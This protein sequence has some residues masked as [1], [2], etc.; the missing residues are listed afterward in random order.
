MERLALVG[1]AL[2]AAL[3]AALALSPYAFEWRCL[4]CKNGATVETDPA[5]LA[6][7]SPGLARAEVPPGFARTL[8][9]AGTMTIEMTLAPRRVAQSG[10]ARIL[11]HS[12]SPYSRNFTLGQD[13]DALVLRFRTGDVD[14]NGRINEI[15]L[16]EVFTDTAEIRLEVTHDRTGTTVVVDGAE[17]FE[18]PNARADFTSWNDGFDL[19]VGNE[20]T[21]D[22]P[23]LGVV[24][25]LVIA[26][27]PEAPALVD[28]DFA[29]STEA[30]SAPA[31]LS[32]LQIPRIFLHLI[33]LRGESF[34]LQDFILHM[35]MLLPIGF[36]AVLTFGRERR[37]AT[38]IAVSTLT[39]L[40][41]AFAVEIAQHFTAT[42]TM[43]ALDFLWGALG[44]LLGAAAGQAVRRCAHRP[45]RTGALGA[46][47]GAPD[48]RADAE[49]R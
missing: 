16:P 22:R 19:I 33:P 38:L 15:T 46:L 30:S 1:L 27:G 4:I 49:G 25:R 17:T 34:K 29:G 20:S 31:Q 7:R 36:L 18:A 48:D 26:G 10:P 32:D 5:G 9:E 45:A 41:Y 43:S 44:G 2:W 24:R 14:R 37:E 40:A 42:R 8:T 11:T 12:A 35:G 21:G 47:A 39:V 6:F 28:L 23:W 13:R 3:A